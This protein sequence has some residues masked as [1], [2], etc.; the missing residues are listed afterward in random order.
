MSP[1]DQQRAIL[2]AIDDPLDQTEE[3]EEEIRFRQRKSRIAKKILLDKDIMEVFSD[4]E[5]E[6]HAAFERLGY[7]ATLSD[8]QTVHFSLMAI[9]QL[10]AKLQGYVMLNEMAEENAETDKNMED[11]QI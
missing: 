10:R 5:V 1:Y 9:E 3:Q 6:H 7:G 4:I 8:Y 11:V 2:D